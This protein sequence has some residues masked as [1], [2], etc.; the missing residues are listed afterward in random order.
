MAQ[1]D[2]HQARL[3]PNP[4]LSVVFR[5]PAGGGKPDIEAGLAADLMSLLTK[6]GQ[7]SAADSRLRA[8]VAEALTI[9]LDVLAETQDRYLAVQTNDRLVAVLEARMAIIDRLL[10]IARSRLDVG[11]GT[12]LDL[13]S[14]QAQRVEL[15][16]ELAERR[17]D[18]QDTW[19]QLIRLIGEPSLR[20]QWALT[21]WEGPFTPQLP[22]SEW[23]EFGLTHRPEVQQQ[24]FEL[25]AL[26]AELTLTRYATFATADVGLEVERSGGDWAAG[27]SASM[28][29]PIFD[30]GKARSARA[31]A[32]VIE[33]RHR[34]T[35]LRRQII[36]EIRRAYAAYVSARENLQR[37]RNELIPLARKGLEQAEAQFRGGQTDATGLLQAEQELRAAE[38]RQVELERRSAEALIR[39]E[40]AVGGPAVVRRGASSTWPASRPAA[41]DTRTNNQSMS[42]NRSAEGMA[43]GAQ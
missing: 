1:A 40:R 43:E 36:E 24:R 34:L 23:I 12:R 11:E 18:R 22:E 14:L 32:S 7:A 30:V 37:V 38:T 4:I 25:A 17:L 42:L 10:G 29:L 9:V 19:L 33:S 8:S 21:A 3:L 31:Q 27:P 2:A 5:F 20:Q 6:P 39:L 26:G 15:L 16:T 28:S 35:Q 13:L 41:P